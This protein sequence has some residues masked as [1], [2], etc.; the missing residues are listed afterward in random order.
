MSAPPVPKVDGALERNRLLRRLEELRGRG[1]GGLAPY[2][3]AG[4]GGLDTTLAVLRALDAAGAACVELGVPFSDPIADGPVLQ[5]AA[6]R[7]LARGTTLDE[8]LALVAELR[9]GS[10]CFAA[11]TLPVAL[12]SYANP[13]LRRGW[14]SVCAGAAASGVDALVVAD[15]PV[16]EGA[17]MQ[18]AALRHGLCPIFFASPTTADERIRAAAAASRGFL[19]VVARAGVT[20]PRTEFDAAT[21]GFLRRVRAAAP[22]PLALGFGIATAEQ[23]RLALEHAELAIVGSAL[24]ERV[25]EACAAAPAALACS[26]AARAAGDFLRALQRGVPPG[27]P[28]RSRHGSCTPLSATS[29]LPWTGRSWRS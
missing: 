17:A 20:G 10:G 11:S 3:T 21:V 26:A 15:L 28:D 29:S 4:D 12:M 14:E 8:V 19:Y 13:L 9:C 18:N 7:A 24:V 1:L 22:L 23:V 27:A 16:E 6:E 5:Q 2:V 25:H